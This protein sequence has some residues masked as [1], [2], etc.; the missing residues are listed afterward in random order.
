MR[1]SV[2]CTA[3]QRAAVL[4]LLAALTSGQSQTSTAPPRTH[5]GRAASVENAT[6]TAARGVFLQRPIITGCLA[7]CGAQEQSC[8]TECQVCVEKNKCKLLDEACSSCFQE[9]H[10]MKSWKNRA[11]SNTLDNGGMPLIHDGIRAQLM[12]AKLEALKSQRELRAARGGVLKAQRE[13][14]WATEERKSS[15]K[16]VRVAKTVL[17]DAKEK[18]ERWKLQN[19]ERLKAMRAKARQRRRE[20]KEARR[21]LLRAKE[22]L[23]KA[24]LRLQTSVS[25]ETEVASAEDEEGKLRRL[26]VKRQK[27]VVEAEKA[28]VKRKKD[29]DWL[30]RGL[31]KQVV[32]ARHGVKHARE[33]LLTARAMERVSREWREEAKLRYM[34]AAEQVQSRDEAASDLKD[35]LAENPLPTYIPQSTTPPE[36]ASAYICGCGWRGTFIILLLTSLWGI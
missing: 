30:D 11:D 2:G 4:L 18:V 27:A 12:D 34:N 28:L 17:K 15:E 29:A 31:R 25:N 22:R 6:P 9:V 20:Q 33:D 23:R 13:A 8:V 5:S 26:V 19:A 35:K 1:C 14:E 7:E 21:D 3:L 32:K 24:K 10:A 16:S 36:H